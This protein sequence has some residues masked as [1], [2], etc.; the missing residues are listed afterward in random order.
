MASLICAEPLVFGTPKVGENG[1]SWMITLRLQLRNVDEFS[2]ARK[3]ALTGRTG[4]KE[5]WSSR[6]VACKT[7]ACQHPWQLGDR[8]ELEPGWRT[9]S[10]FGDRSDPELPEKLRISLTAGDKVARWRALLNIFDMPVVDITMP[11]IMIRGDNC[12]FRCAV[13]QASS[14][15]GEWYLIL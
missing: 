4:F 1:D 12:C 13:G 14:Q 11:H 5:L 2:S 15:S 10:G 8:I 3:E 6:F 7:R 9:F